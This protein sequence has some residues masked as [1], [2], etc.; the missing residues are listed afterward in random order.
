ME[1]QNVREVSLEQTEMQFVRTRVAILSSARRTLLRYINCKHARS[2]HIRT[3]KS[4][5]LYAR[6]K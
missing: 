3:C 4:L 2:N 5:N 1:R 6:E